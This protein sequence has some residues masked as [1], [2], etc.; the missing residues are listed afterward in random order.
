MVTVLTSKIGEERLYAIV[1]KRPLFSFRSSKVNIL[2][3]QMIH[4][5]YWC[6]ILRATAT[7]RLGKDQTSRLLVTV[8]AVNGDV[9]HAK[10]IPEG[11]ET[12]EEGIQGR[13]KVEIGRDVAVAKAKNFAL[14]VFMKKFFLLKEVSS[15]IEN[16][17]LVYYPYW[18]VDVQ[19]RHKRF[20]RAVDAIHGEFND[21]VAYLLKEEGC[22]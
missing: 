18:V 4:Y 19:I 15:E 13:L 5:P 7:Q 1:I 12:R 6:V 2:G 11:S 16:V 17:R 20:R 14:D 8:D 21:R 10:N 9:G 3:S 22:T